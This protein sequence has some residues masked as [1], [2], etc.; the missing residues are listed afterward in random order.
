VTTIV[1]VKDRELDGIKIKSSVFGSRHGGNKV[2]GIVK[3]NKVDNS[4]SVKRSVN[5]DNVSE[6]P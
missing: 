3:R 2:F 5:S 4:S 6:G 1:K